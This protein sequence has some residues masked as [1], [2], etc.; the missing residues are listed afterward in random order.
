MRNLLLDA[1]YHEGEVSNS[2]LWSSNTSCFGQARAVLL[3]AESSGRGHVEAAALYRNGQLATLCRSFSK[4]QSTESEAALGL[5][6]LVDLPLCPVDLQAAAATSVLEVACPSATVQVQYICFS[7]M[8][9][10]RMSDSWAWL[11]SVMCQENCTCVCLN[12]SLVPLKEALYQPGC[13]HSQ[14]SVHIAYSKR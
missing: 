13:Q 8:A 14:A 3:G 11:E 2:N 6:A 5:T 4:G 12:R 1:S 7:G 10:G 9:T